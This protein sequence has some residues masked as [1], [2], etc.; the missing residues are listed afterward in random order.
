MPLTSP[1]SVIPQQNKHNQTF[2][3]SYTFVPWGSH[4]VQPKPLRSSLDSTRL[5][6]KSLKAEQTNKST[7]AP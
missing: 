2:T 3:V 7:H 5:S 6:P 4:P 1:Q